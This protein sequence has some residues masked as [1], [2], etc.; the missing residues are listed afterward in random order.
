MLKMM[1]TVMH[2][3]AWFARKV[4]ALFLEFGVGKAAILDGLVKDKKGENGWPRVG[5]FLTRSQH[6]VIA[7]SPTP[8]G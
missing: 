7:P 5:L 4:V 8:D 2:L 6:Y 3:E 1:N